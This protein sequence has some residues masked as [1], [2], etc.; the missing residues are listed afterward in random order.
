MKVKS[1]SPPVCKDIQIVNLRQGIP[2]AG[3]F[4]YC[5]LLFCALKLFVYMCTIASA[6]NHVAALPAAHLRFA[7]VKTLLHRGDL[8]ADLEDAWLT[9]S[10]PKGIWTSF[11]LDTVAQENVLQP[12]RG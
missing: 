12:V 10:Y 1:S 11:R 3:S 5:P 8:A 6:F 4:L 9:K 2:N 7:M